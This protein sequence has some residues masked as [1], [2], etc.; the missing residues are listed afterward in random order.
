MND[1]KKR[2]LL[3]KHLFDKFYSQKTIIENA[4]GAPLEWERLDRKFGCFVRKTVGDQ[5]LKDRDNWPSVDE[6]MVDA[7][8]K[9]TSA[10]KPY[11]QNLK[12]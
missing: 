4:F 8:I 5:G 6:R 11:I 3:N 1:D 9:L 7:M 12:D 10:F 2:K